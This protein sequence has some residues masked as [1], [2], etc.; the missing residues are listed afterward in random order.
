MPHSSK[1]TDQDQCPE[2]AMRSQVRQSLAHFRDPLKRIFP[3]HLSLLPQ[4]NEVY[5]LRLAYMERLALGDEEL[6]QRGA[7]FAK[8]N[9]IHTNH[10]LMCSGQPLQPSKTSSVRLK[11]FFQANQFKT[12]YATHGLFPYRGKFHPQMIKALLNIMRLQPQHDTVLDPM[13]G[14][15]TVMIEAALMGIHSVGIDISP[16]CVLMAKAKVAGLVAPV[17]LLHQY[18]SIADQLFSFFELRRE[19]RSLPLSTS[20]QPSFIDLINTDRP[21]TPPSLGP[22]ADEVGDILQL[23]YL[24]SVGYAERRK[25]KTPR[26]LFPEILAKYIRLI[27]KVQAV[28]K[29]AELPLG[30]VDIKSADARTLDL[31]SESVDGVIFSPPYS[32][33]IDYLKNDF[34]QLEYLGCDVEALRESLVGLR[35]KG[36]ERVSAYFEDMRLIMEEVVRV[37]RPGRFCTIIVG[38]N[39]N[40]LA[41][42]LRHSENQVRG[43]EERLVEFGEHLGLAPVDRINRQITGMRNIMRNEW[44]LIFQKHAP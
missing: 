5:E 40:Q 19:E 16:F 18:A 3:E 27:E 37:L 1:Q 11:T 6:I 22:R 17:E 44:I 9:G 10:F 12:G 21:A 7:Y 28:I 36:K 24:D 15:A 34:A 38:S 13:M 33:A 8:V 41:R 20:H 42:I 30:R 14:S 32:F 26:E 43:I 39:T 31:P 2:A 23:A 29:D 4:V 25:N 35:G